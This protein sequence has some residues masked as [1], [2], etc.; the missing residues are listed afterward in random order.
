MQ[1][2]IIHKNKMNQDA[3]RFISEIVKPW[4]TLNQ[5]LGK[6][7]SMNP[8]INDFVTKA[9]GLAVAIK[10]LP[11][12]TQKIEPATL[13]SKSLDYLI[14]SDLADSMKHG[15]LRKPG[16]ECKLTVSSMFERNQEA[17]V[18]FLRNRISIIHNTHG[19]IDFMQCAM[20]S[21]NFVMREMGIKTNWSPKIFNNSGDFS[22]EIKVHVSK[23]NQI[24]W[25][26]MTLEIVQLNDKNEYENVDLNGTVKFTLTSEF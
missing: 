20:T 22:D 23:N 11:E 3:I 21:A 14:I 16:R 9:I 5:E 6:P 12:A 4:E 17:K 8:E 1:E 18:R 2:S 26:G 10:H 24:V 13:I 25:T 19:K 7:F 15:K